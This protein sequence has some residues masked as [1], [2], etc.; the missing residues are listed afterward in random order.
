MDVSTISSKVICPL[1]PVDHKLKSRRYNLA[2]VGS[3]GGDLTE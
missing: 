3:I 1:L 2:L